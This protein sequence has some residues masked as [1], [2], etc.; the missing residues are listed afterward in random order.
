MN[1]H[2]FSSKM[3][4]FISFLLGII[5]FT[6]TN[7]AYADF[8]C[9][10]PCDSNHTWTCGDSWGCCGSSP[11]CSSGGACGDWCCADCGGGGTGDICYDG[12]LSNVYKPSSSNACQVTITHYGF[13][14]DET[15]SGGYRDRTIYWA[16]ITDPVNIC[17]VPPADNILY[18]ASSL[19]RRV[20]VNGTDD[21]CIG[22][23]T[24]DPPY[25]EDGFVFT[26]DWSASSGRNV[27]ITTTANARRIGHG[28]GAGWELTSSGCTMSYDDYCTTTHRGPVDVVGLNDTCNAYGEPISVTENFTLY[29][30]GD[31]ECTCG[32]SPDP[33]SP[34][35]CA[36]DC[37]PR[38]TISGRVTD[39]VT[40]QGIGGITMTNTCNAI[41]APLPTTALTGASIG[42]FSIP[43]VPR[44]EDFC[45]RFPSSVPGYTGP[46]RS[47]EWQV[48]GYACGVGGADRG[49]TTICH[50]GALTQDLAVDNAYYFTY[51]PI[52][53]PTPTPAVCQ[54]GSDITLTWSASTGATSYKLMVDDITASPLGGVNCASLNSGDSCHDSSTNSH[55][56]TITLGNNYRWWVQACN[57]PWCSASSTESTFNCSAPPTQPAWIKV[58]GDVHS[59]KRAPF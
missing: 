42:S 51:T 46:N 1:L 12:Y 36:A 28:F 23:A 57:G 35:F 27:S 56:V 39:S 22:S 3:L 15:G 25:Q 47:Y 50:D 49:N 9:T 53:V 45:L 44:A 10:D 48:T 59:N 29:Y 32:E 13:D 5:L 41:V 24:S 31:G 17:Y 6:F 58:S 40:G 7:T 38:V 2:S 20:G 52:A 30:C 11:W 54:S 18:D 33:Y 16:G 37:T 14:R 34:S 55:Q 43:N 26:N 19:A 8:G 4:I 21:Y